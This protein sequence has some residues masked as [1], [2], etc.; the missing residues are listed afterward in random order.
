MNN[1]EYNKLSDKLTE[2]QTS[3]IRLEIKMEGVESDIKEI[4]VEDAQ[5]NQLLAEH[6]AGVKTAQA[7]LSVEIENREAQNSLLNKKQ[8]ETDLRLQQLEF[9]PNFFASFKKILLWIAAFVGAVLTIG[10][11]FHAF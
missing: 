9:L 7:R 6:I 1:A 5:Q 11:L 10:K 8:E 4:K 2:I 3:I